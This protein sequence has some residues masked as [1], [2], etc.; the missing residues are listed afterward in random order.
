MR[1]KRLGTTVFSTFLL[2]RKSLV[3]FAVL[4]V[5]L[6]AVT[7]GWN[8]IFRGSGPL[9]EVAGEGA[10]TIFLF[11]TGM[12]F[13]EK[14]MSFCILNSVSKAERVISGLIVSL[15]VSLGAAAVC[16][17]ARIGVYGA[18]HFSASIAKFIRIAINSGFFP[19]AALPADFLELVLFWLAVFWFG[20]FLGALRQRIGSGKLLLALFVIAVLFGGNLVLCARAGVNPLL[21]L[22]IPAAYMQKTRMTSMFLSLLLAAVFGFFGLIIRN[23]KINEE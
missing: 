16:T 12:G 21:W 7:A 8:M 10:V 5:I 3:I 15:A 9:P 20:Y 4:E 17:A 11:L 6:I 13:Y 23:E 22:F 19:D 18:D 2:L 14:H 1:T